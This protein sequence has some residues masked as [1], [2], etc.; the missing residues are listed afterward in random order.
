MF[1]ILVRATLPDPSYRNNAKLVMP[2]IHKNGTTTQIMT[3]N[4]VNAGYSL[5]PPSQSLEVAST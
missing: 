3:L 5:E 1:L 2:Y 4:P